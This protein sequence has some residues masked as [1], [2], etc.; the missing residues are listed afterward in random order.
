MKVF[1]SCFLWFWGRDD[2]AGPSA[3]CDNMR[4]KRRLLLGVFV[5]PGS[6]A[7]LP[8]TSVPSHG[9]AGRRGRALLPLGCGWVLFWDMEL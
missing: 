5:I 4:G 7:V 3:I 1:T 9:A 6:G 8:V 2:R